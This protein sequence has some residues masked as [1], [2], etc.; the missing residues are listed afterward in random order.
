MKLTR[1]ITLLTIACLAALSFG[2]CSKV[3]EPDYREKEYGYVQFKLYK[4]ASYEG[5]KA[6]VS[7]LDYLSDAAKLKVTLRYDGNDIT[8]TLVLNSADG[9]VAEFGLRSDKMKLL[10]GS[11]RVLTF[12]L[13]DKLDQPLYTST[14]SEAHTS[15]EVVAGGLSVHDLLA[16]TVERGK[17][18]FTL[19]KDMSDFKDN[20]ATKAATSVYTFDEISYV[21]V[22]VKTGNTTLEPFEML[23]A[24]F[25]IHFTDDGIEDGYQTS[26]FVCD[27]LLTLRAGNYEIVRYEVYD[28]GKDLLE[29]STDVKAQFSVSDNKVTEAE[30]PVSLHESDPYIK[31]Y[32][33]LYEIWKGLNGKD[34]YYN[35]EDYPVG[36]NWDFNKDPDLWGDQPGV[37]L[38]S[39]GRIAMINLSGYGFYGHMPAAIGQ[40][41]EL[42]ELYL[43][44]HND[45]NLSEYDPTLNPGTGTSNR[46]ENHKKYMSMLHPATPASEP[47]ARALIE[48]DVFIPAVEYYRNM[49]ESEVIEEGTGRSLIQ[50]MDMSAGKVTNGLLSL[51]AEFGNLT[52]LEQLF[53]ANSK[54]TA[55][56]MEMENLISLTDIEVYNCPDM[57]EFP[58]AL[59][60][61]PSLVSANLACNP[62]WNA[63][64]ALK[65]LKGLATGPSKEKIQIL[66]YLGNNLEI[67]PKE[68]KNM[69]KIGLLDFTSNKI[70]TIEEAWG[71]EIKPVQ[72]YLDNNKLTSFPVDENGIFCFMEDAET[73]SAR[74]NKLTQFPDI[75][76]AKSI[77]TI[78]TVDF[79]YNEISSVQNGENFKGINVETLNL[80][81]NSTITKYPV[82]FAKSNSKLM[83]MNLRGCNVNEIPEGSFTYENSLY[84]TSL[85]LSYNDLS[86]LPWEMHA[87]N[88]PYLYG[89]ELSFNKF[90]EFPW[91]PLD[92]QYLTVFALRSQ[93]D[94]NGARCLADWPEG[95]YQHRGLRGLYLGSNN[96][97][98]IEDTISTIC[99][100]LDISDNPDIVF[101]ASDICYAIQQGAY[102]LIYDKTQNILN[103]DILLN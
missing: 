26:S 41:T 67:I 96:F 3:E 39:N 64:E 27:T 34:W 53:I 44:S 28:D 76:S 55:L 23:P 25:S 93:R 75:F 13:Y 94:D 17:V 33:A 70:H 92:S 42:V 59:A 16:S 74:N 65:G 88:L 32:Y 1:F 90:K 71:T 68:I 20:P 45:S 14:P 100:Y 73:F 6:V 51:P 43:G 9:D 62:Q 82:E 31:D 30:V 103:C 29:M 98:K 36:T 99:Y 48:N 85:D 102:I 63:E 2:S 49:N 66:Y 35:G 46:F 83:Y 58:M 81:N 7:Q 69:K 38:H 18:R 97:G 37:S 5:T 78:V 72:L 52:K 11:Y 89:V 60:K 12:T 84:L 50:P 24:D 4:E 57:T 15:F 86:D 56:P 77:Y 87:G 101:D 61:L 47:I 40:L 95:I 8:Q 22:T 21:S 79:S 19:V 80:A 91:E 54:I 10:S